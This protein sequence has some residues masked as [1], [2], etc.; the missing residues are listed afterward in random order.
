MNWTAENAF[1]ICAF[2]GAG[3]LFVSLMLGDITSGLGSFLE[4]HGVDLFHGSHDGPG[5]TDSRVLST[6]L[7]TF[8][9]IGY[10]TLT[11]GATLLGATLSAAASGF[12]LAGVVYYFAKLLYSQQSNSSVTAQDLLGRSAQVT[13]SI[14]KGGVGMV[15]CLVGE[16]R[17][18]K[19][20][21]TVDGAAIK[22]GTTVMIDEL[23][24]DC[25]LV[26][27]DTSAGWR[28]ALN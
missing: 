16:E 5:F 1:L 2:V 14:P 23:G 12:I 22:A 20:A 3:F 24:S 28:R 15:S 18:E 6:F 10:L 17:I 7:A 11:N 21:R 4:I 25:L 8:G 19:T 27:T 26:S 13:V 9:C